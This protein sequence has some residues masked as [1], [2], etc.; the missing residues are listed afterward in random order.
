GGARRGRG[1]PDAGLGAQVQRGPGGGPRGRPG[2]ADRPMTGAPFTVRTLHLDLP[3]LAGAF[4]R[5]LHEAGVPTTAERAARFAQSLELVRP[6]SKRRLYWTAR[7]VLVTDRAQVR[8]FDEVFADVFG[9]REPG[10]GFEHEEAETTASPS[11]RTAGGET[12]DA[13]GIVAGGDLSSGPP[14]EG[15]DRINP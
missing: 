1:G 7:G 11:D 10:T 14:D 8:A 4:S 9:V 15:G 6:V 2:G 13:R 12:R 3:A 5:R